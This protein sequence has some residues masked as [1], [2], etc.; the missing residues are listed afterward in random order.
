MESLSQLT[1][2]HQKQLSSPSE[3]FCLRSALQA[4]ELDQRKPST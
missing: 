3:S 2:L 4:S 1:A